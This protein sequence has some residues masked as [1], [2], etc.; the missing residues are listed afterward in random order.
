MAFNEAF[1]LFQFLGALSKRD[2][3]AFEKLTPEAQ[4]AVAP[5]VL[6][7]WMTG[8][9]DAAQIVRINTFV[10]PFTFSLGQDK[11]LLCKLLAAAATGKTGRYS[12]I[13]GPGAK[14]EK[15]RLEA[16]KQFY[17]V[18]TREAKEY[19]L[20]PETIM[21]MAHQ[22]G[23]DDDELKKLKAE[24]TKDEPGRTEKP[25]AGAKKRR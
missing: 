16:I 9:S 22:L 3:N 13:K 21:E 8:T 23:W 12:W 19:S 6:Q 18:S 14:A 24:V 17:G 1:D 5:F 15:L 4:K 2:I 10:N 20:D 11:A 25:G 7:R